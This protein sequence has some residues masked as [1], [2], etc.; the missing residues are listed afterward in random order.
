MGRKF[1]ISAIS[2]PGF[3]R[4]GVIFKAEETFPASSEA[5]TIAVMWGATTGR[6]FFKTDQVFK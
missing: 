6:Q 4:P 5:L 3:L 2:L 1:D